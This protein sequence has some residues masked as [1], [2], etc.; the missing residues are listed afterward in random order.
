M[1]SKEELRLPPGSGCGA[2]LSALINNYLAAGN[3]FSGLLTR[4]SATGV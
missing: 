3:D 2:S 4:T 1:V